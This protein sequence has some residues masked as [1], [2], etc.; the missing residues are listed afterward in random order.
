MPLDPSTVSPPPPPG[1]G[2]KLV[3]SDGRATAALTEWMARL[4]AWLAATVKKEG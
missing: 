2:V 4:V 3:T 1:P